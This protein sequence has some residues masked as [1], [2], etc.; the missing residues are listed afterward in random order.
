MGVSKHCQR[1]PAFDHYSRF[2][3][4]HKSGQRRFFSLGIFVFKKQ[5]ADGL[6]ELGPVNVLH[7]VHKD[8]FLYSMMFYKLRNIHPGNGSTVKARIYYVLFFVMGQKERSNGVSERIFH[9]QQLP[10]VFHI[11]LNNR[12]RAAA[13]TDKD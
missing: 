6:H 2:N 4:A 3:P 1:N 11:R 13:G 9:N 7:I 12:P 8:N 5:I 10:A